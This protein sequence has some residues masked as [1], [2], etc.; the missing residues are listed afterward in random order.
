MPELQTNLAAAG[1]AGLAI[2]SRSERS[3]VARFERHLEIIGDE[4]E[5]KLTRKLARPRLLRRLLSGR[6]CT[7][8]D[9]QSTSSCRRRARPRTRERIGAVPLAQAGGMEWLPRITSSGSYSA[10]TPRSRA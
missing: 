8:D 7:A 1:C 4:V 6:Q 5:S 2:C 10:F 3:S 9:A